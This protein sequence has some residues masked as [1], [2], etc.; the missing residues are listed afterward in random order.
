LIDVDEFDVGSVTD[1]NAAANSVAENAA[2]GT[3]V[4]V[5]AAA[6]D[7]DGTRTRS[8]TAST[9]TLADGSRFTAR[10]ES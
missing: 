5:T 3:T 4:G 6:A 1:S 9:T 7:A 10:P 8:P 2:N